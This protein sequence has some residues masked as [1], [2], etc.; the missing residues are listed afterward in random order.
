MDDFFS[1]SMFDDCSRKEIPKDEN[2]E[3]SYVGVLLTIECLRPTKPQIKI[4][5]LLSKIDDKKIQRINLFNPATY[6]I[7]PINR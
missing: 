7:K 5:K 2:P 6:S 3:N 1:G 4:N